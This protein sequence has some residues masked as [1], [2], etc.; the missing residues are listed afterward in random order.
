MTHRFIAAVPCPT[1]VLLVLAA[2]LVRPDAAAAQS[3]RYEVTGFRNARFGMTEEQVRASARSAFGARDDEMTVRT[4]ATDG[5]TT[6]IVH[7]PVLEPD[8]GEGRVCYTFGYRSRT[9]IQVNVIWGEDTNP[10][11]SDRGIVAGALRLK[12]HFLGFGWRQGSVRDEVPIDD[13]SV[14]LFSGDD[15]RHGAARLVLEG[16]QYRRFVN[17]VLTYS[18]PP[19]TPPRL[20]IRYIAERYDPDILKLRRRDF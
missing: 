19:T 9:L 2:L 11:L 6:L 5:T 13:N 20:S 14:L 10:P 3:S 17:G 18:P 4:N 7:V 1:V 15:E 8:L 12:G 16:V